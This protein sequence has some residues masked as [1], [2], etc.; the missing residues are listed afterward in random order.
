MVTI[1]A[2]THPRAPLMPLRPPAAGTAPRPA[3]LARRLVRPPR[4]RRIPRLQKGIAADAIRDSPTPVERSHA[5]STDFPPRFARR[6]ATPRPLRTAHESRQ[7]DHP[8]QRADQPP[9]SNQ[10]PD[11]VGSARP[12]ERSRKNDLAWIG[13]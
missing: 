12:P 1:P 6:R 11:V 13:R 9:R 4:G 3:Q 7:L 10:R 5:P 2:I 8:L